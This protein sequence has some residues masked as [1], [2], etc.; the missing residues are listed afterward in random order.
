MAGIIEAAKAKIRARG[1]S[2]QDRWKAALAAGHKEKA[3]VLGG[4]AAG[5][6]DALAMLEMEQRPFDRAAGRGE[7]L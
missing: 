3:A 6:M 5:L 1:Q 2:N 7:G 4:Y